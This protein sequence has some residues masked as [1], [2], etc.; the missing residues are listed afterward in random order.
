[1][2]SGLRF[3]VAVIDLNLTGT[4]DQLHYLAKSYGRNRFYSETRLP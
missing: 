4:A 2:G 3:G 1:M